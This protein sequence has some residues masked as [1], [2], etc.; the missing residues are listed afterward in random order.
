MLLGRQQTFLK[1]LVVPFVRSV[2][3][4]TEAGRQDIT[5]GVS[6]YM[7]K[8]NASTRVTHVMLISC[9]PCHDSTKHLNMNADLNTCLRAFLELADNC[10]LVSSQVLNVWLS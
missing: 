8:S 7:C 2:A 10:L 1:F 5:S 3:A 4:D 9:C 6:M